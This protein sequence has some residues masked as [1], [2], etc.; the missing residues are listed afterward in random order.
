MA[1]AVLAATSHAAPAFA[2]GKP[3]PPTTTKAGKPKP[4]AESLSAEAKTDYETGKVL[5]TDGDFAGALIKFQAAYDK[6]ND[7]RLLWN[8]AACEKNLRHYAKA[9]RLITRYTK[10]GGALLT[11]ADLREA[12]ELAG[13]LEPLTTQVTFQVAEAGADL[14]IDDEKVGTTPLAEPL[15][16]DVGMRHFRVVKAGFRPYDTSM[17]IG[18]AKT[19]T[20]DVKLEP[21]GGRLKVAAPPQATVTVDDKVVGQGPQDVA[22]TVGGHVLRVTAPTMRAFQTEVT[23]Q[24]NQTRT[25]DVTLEPEGA[26]AAGPELRVAVG[27]DDPRPRSPEE[28]L[29]VYLDGS[30]NATTPRGVQKSWREDAQGAVVDYV[31]YPIAAG[32]HTAHVRFPGCEGAETRVEVVPGKPAEVKGVLRPEGNFFSRG[33][34]G[35]PDW[36]RVSAGMWTTTTHFNRFYELLL[37]KSASDNNG[38]RVVTF[39]SSKGD[40]AAAG[41]ALSIGLVGR[42][43]TFL[44]DLRYASGSTT[45]STNGMYTPNGAQSRAVVG[46]IDGTATIHTYYAGLRFGAKVPL[47]YASI[48]AGPGVAFAVQDISSASYGQHAE[49]SLHLS[50]W[51]ALDVQ[52][53]CDGFVQAMV[54]R[55]AVAESGDP[56]GSTS[57]VFSLGYQ[58]NQRCR[59]E[60]GGAYRIEGSTR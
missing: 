59:R 24:D 12:K 46:P 51:A 60:Q 35:Y 11:P 43:L 30:A 47:Q 1:V 33:P 29:S 42:W 57:F 41:P 2:Q 26:G 38:D 20:V 10:E 39:G 9:L 37:R 23:I 19:A 50:G 15:L 45:G 48:A 58:P 17:P 13:V 7:P 27:C 36:W 52:P 55:A 34:A 54:Q 21:E 44:F 56:S 31:S 22:L 25:L 8:I 53:I 3:T 32:T 18:G 5:F 40:V 6:V 16:V 49:P 4:L 28:G 14:F